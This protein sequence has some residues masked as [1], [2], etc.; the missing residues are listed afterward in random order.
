MN[1][2]IADYLRVVKPYLHP[3]LV[4]AEALLPIQTLARNLPPCTLAMFECRLGAGESRVDLLVWLS[5]YTPN[6]AE[7]FAGVTV[8]QACTDFYQEWVQPKSLLHD[9]VTALGLEFDL[10]GQ[11]SHLLTPCILLTLNLEIVSDG[12][13][14]KEIANRLHSRLPGHSVSPKIESHLQLCANSLPKGARIANLGVM[15]SRLVP[16]V[17]VVVKKIH[18][19]QWLGY[20]REIGW[21]EAPNGLSDLVSTLSEFVDSI[22]LS[23][24]IS[25]TIEPRIGLECHLSKQ[26]RV[27][28]RWQ[29]FLEE[30]VAWR[31][32]TSTKKD[33]VLAWPGLSQKSD[34]PE[35][36]PQNLSRGDIFLKTQMLSFF[37]RNIYGIKI[38][39]HPSQP[40]AAKAYLAFGHEWFDTSSLIEKKQRIS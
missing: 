25:D 27:D 24:D 40:L 13:R 28:S 14:L 23:F 32:C 30:L 17:R 18:P 2:S 35:S 11:S 5:N 16:T 10:V 36:W 7:S 21:G 12:W 20:L 6:L 4:S 22:A 26:L 34:S 39:Y 15:L 29:S 9:T 33:A 1:S 31:L 3:Q 37:W 19:T 8:W 38:V